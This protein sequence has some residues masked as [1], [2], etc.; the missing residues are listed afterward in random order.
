M[1]KITVCLLIIIPTTMVHAATYVDTIPTQNNA[2]QDHIFMVNISENG[3]HLPSPERVIM[4]GSMIALPTETLDSLHIRYAGYQVKDHYVDIRKISGVTA[5]YNA[6]TLE[7]AID[8]PP[9]W[10]P[11]QLVKIPDRWN[12]PYYA[13]NVTPGF[14]FDYDIYDEHPRNSSYFSSWM[15]GRY[16]NHFGYVNLSGQYINLHQGGHG[17]SRFKRLNTSWVFNNRNSAQK[18]ILGDI[19][20]DSGNGFGGVYMGGIQLRR[21]YT[22]RPDI[23]TYPSLRLR[24]TASTPSSLDFFVNGYRSASSHVDPGA[25]VINNIPFINGDGT[26]TVVTTDANGRQVSS[27]IPYSIQTDMLRP[28]LSDFNF[29]VGALR[30]NYGWQDDQ[31]KNIA[32]SGSYRYGMTDRLTALSHIEGAD[33]LKMLGGGFQFNMNS[34]GRLDATVTMSDAQYSRR[35]AREYL[36]YSKQ[37][38]RANINIS[39]IRSSGGYRDLDSFDSDYG[40][41]LASDQIFASYALGASAGVLGAGFIYQR[42]DIG[43]THKIA[44]LS[45]STLVAN[46][47]SLSISYSKAFSEDRAD[48]FMLGISLPFGSN[49]RIGVQNMQSNSNAS[50]NVVSLTHN[51]GSDLGVDWDLNY[52][53]ERNADMGY[54]DMSAT[55]KMP[56]FIASGGAYGYRD[57]TPWVGLQGSVVFMDKSVFFTKA[58]GNAFVKV[59]TY[60]VEGVPYYLDGALKGKTNNQ[61]IGFISD[62][63]P[64][65]K[66]LVTIDPSYLPEDVNVTDVRKSFF[67]PENSGYSAKFSLQNLNDQVLLRLVPPRGVTLTSGSEIQDQH[68]HTVALLGNG[69][70]V[71]MKRPRVTETYTLVSDGQKKCSFQLSAENKHGIEVETCAQ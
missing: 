24:G 15:N 43:I 39:H 18:L 48:N 47:F 1:N 33:G 59:D 4:N 26:M 67:V 12:S 54:R 42:D 50:T 14:V 20:T 63:V 66:N 53:R 38:Q 40:S 41:A 27:R 45:Y 3:K 13:E 44:N 46:L 2:R 7:L 35:G 16:F 22:L 11:L 71:S 17:Y 8:I 32:L 55:W 61:G 30:Y 70:L 49:T 69:D 10:I 68:H 9:D 51:S 36:G 25:Y 5:I 21:D 56:A 64:Y 6:K 57:L 31:Y 34:W 37:F 62:V 58:V 19:Q 60:G 29:S 28:G 65:E 23:V 52:S